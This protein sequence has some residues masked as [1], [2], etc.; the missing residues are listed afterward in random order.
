MLIG[1]NISGSLDYD[2]LFG[3]IDKGGNFMQIFTQNPCEFSYNNNFKM[4]DDIKE[5]INIKNIGFVIHG[6]FC[7]N[8]CR[9]S[10]DKIA[11]NSIHLLKKDLEIANKYG[12]IGVI[13]HMGKDTEKLGEK[14]ALDNYV[15][16][17]NYVLEQT[18][19]SIIILETGANCGSE[20][21]SRLNILGEIRNRILDREKH[22]IKFCIDTCH[23]YSSGYNLADEN[24]V[25]I[26]EYYIDNTLGWKNI[27][28]AHINDS[29]DNLCS[30]KDRHADISD[31]H[32]SQKN[33]NAFLKFIGFFVKRN[34]PLI[35]E[36]PSDNIDYEDQI[37]LIKFFVN[38]NFK[39][40]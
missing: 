39:I 5:I 27:I 10:H 13:I 37:N 31:G 16:N 30:K 32:I 40:I 36:T 11:K 21:G 28:V 18:K 38:N 3:L 25:D 6:S 34:I 15:S 12:A 4:S 33:M 29:K 8:L 35:L 23:I 26:L 7:I 1:Y 24:F 19:N 14:K 22:R 2:K 20:V 17:L 9:S